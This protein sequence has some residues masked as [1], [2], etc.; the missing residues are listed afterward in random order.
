MAEIVYKINRE[1]FH[2]IVI[3]FSCYSWPLYSTDCDHYS[4]YVNNGY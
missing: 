1:N 2:H 3:D 4:M